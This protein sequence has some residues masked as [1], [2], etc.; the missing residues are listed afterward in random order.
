MNPHLVFTYNKGLPSELKYWFVEEGGKIRLLSNAIKTP[1][2]YVSADGLIINGEWV[3]QSG[4][5]VIKIDEE[6]ESSEDYPSENIAGFAY[7]DGT[8]LA[9]E[10]EGNLFVFNNEKFNKYQHKY[11]FTVLEDKN[12]IVILTNERKIERERPLS[13]RITPAFIN[14]IYQNESVVINTDGK[15]VAKFNKPLYYL[16]KT[17]KGLLFQVARGDSSGKIIAENDPEFI[18]FCSGETA[19]IGE[20]QLGIVISCNKQLK[21]Y[22]ES[23]WTTI[24]RISDIVAT[25]ANTNFII[26]TD[27]ETIVYPGD[28]LTKPLF[29]LP[30]M[31][32]VHADRKYIYLISQSKRLYVIEADKD[33][34]PFTIE[35]DKYGMVTLTI[36]KQLYSS[37][38]FGKGLVQVWK[39]EDG[40]KVIIRIEPSRLLVPVQSKIEVTNEIIKYVEE[41]KI[42]EVSVELEPI[43]AYIIVSNKGR[44]K[45]TEGNYNALLKLR[46]RY[47]IPTEMP[48]F[49]KIKIQ[50]KEYSYP[51][52]KIEDEI[53][54]DIPITK[55]DV[56][57]EIVIVSLE[58]N[59]YLEA[60][61]E[62]PAKVKEVVEEKG[63]HKVIYVIDGVS[64]KKI[65]KTE[66]E[67]F[68][69]S[70][71]WEYQDPYDNVIITKAG[72]IITIEG[73]KFEVK[74]GIRK[75]TIRG[76]NY[77]RDYLIYGI[78]SP[79]KNIN[80]IID[81]N[82]LYLDISLEY[83]APV[84]VI[85][86]TQIQTSNDG[87]FVFSLDPF[88]QTIIVKIYYSE[89]IKWD[90]VFRL[91]D[92]AKTSMKHALE[93]S[94]IMEENF[95]SMGFFTNV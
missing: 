95:E 4:Q 3:Y 16:G 32:A 22:S 46:V 61:K 73:S 44:V 9:I 48:C 60:S 74:P 93:L 37:L 86:G 20:S 41:I 2:V 49:I 19:Y 54:L 58:R 27:A 24:S 71:V 50:E 13:Y 56:K 29:T 83:R 40:N 17:S 69:W 45:N 84:T 70:K 62:F 11:A 18:T 65:E 1:K 85:Y 77:N 63:D 23:T 66:N 21:Y 75:V 38:K 5:S 34:Q 47:K 26:T 64:K 43:E 51:I 55:E 87:K 88:Y 59:G 25:Y 80:A 39:R 53:S 52:S 68:E 67:I 12:R 79:L 6:K 14:L 91:Q 10:K 72:N 31:E 15:V 35:R 81:K 76:K 36:D 92:I 94:K 57:D 30:A 89:T 7:L 8:V 90:Y 33:Y 82:K 28:S 78:I 42:N